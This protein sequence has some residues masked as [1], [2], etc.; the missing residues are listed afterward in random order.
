MAKKKAKKKRYKKGKGIYIAVRGYRVQAH[1][2]KRPKK[3]RR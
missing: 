1:N 3:R 2:R